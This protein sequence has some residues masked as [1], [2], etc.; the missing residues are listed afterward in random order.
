MNFLYDWLDDAISVVTSIK[1]SLKNAAT[2]NHDKLNKIAIVGRHIFRLS[3]NAS[4]SDVYTSITRYFE[5]DD[6]FNILCNS[7]EAAI[8]AC[9]ICALSE[10]SDDRA[11]FVESIMNMA[12]E[13]QALLMFAIKRNLSQYIDVN[14][15]ND[16][17]EENVDLSD[18][19]K[20][21]V[22]DPSGNCNLSSIS[23][24]K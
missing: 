18:I 15:D 3:E 8:E 23:V 22:Y 16:I 20:T 12:S 10:A 5:C 14:D 11:L 4:I 1:T 19:D 2:I 17:T 6:L 9:L 21:V 24:D 13:D 7:T